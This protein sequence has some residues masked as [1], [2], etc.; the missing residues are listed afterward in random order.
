MTFKGFTNKDFDVFKINGL[1]QRME[2]IKSRIRPKFEDLGEHFAPFL[3]AATGDEMFYHTAKHA[4]RS[5][6][7]PED[8]W[9]AFSSNKRGYKQHP[10]FQIGLFKTHLFVWF[11][12]IYEAPIKESFASILEKNQSEV[13]KAIPD[14]FVWSIDHTKPDAIS[15]KEVENG[16]FP[17]MTHRLK[18]VKKAE[19]LCGI[20]IQRDN[21]V[22][23]KPVQL[24]TQIEQAF[25]SLVP[26]YQYAQRSSV[27]S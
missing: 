1:E 22:L 3:T 14:N 8:T 7:P 18:E 10:H 6:N 23:K 15:H 20:H 12:V 11:A 27:S 13:L 9:V 19:I 2:A 21:P 17:K 16:E 26:L 4:R 5:V 24:Q 25:Q